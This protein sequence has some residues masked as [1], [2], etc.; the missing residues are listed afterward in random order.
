MN[1][2]APIIVSKAEPATRLRAMVVIPCLNEAAHIGRLIERLD[3]AAIRQ[4]MRII[5][6]DGGSTDGTLDILA[7]IARENPRVVILRN[8]RKLQGAAINLAVRELGDAVDCVIRV[9]AHADYPDDFCDR[10]IEEAAAT[11]ADSVVVSMIT[12]G[13]SL[14]QRAAAMAQNSKLGNGGSKHREGAKGQWV[15][16]GHHA[17]M[18]IEPFRAVGGYD[19]TFGHNEDA[20]LDHRLRTA[21]YRI[22]LTGKTRMIYYPRDTVTGLFR[23]YLNYGQ[24]RARNILKHR[25]MPKLRQTLPAMILPLAAGA[26]LA[27]FR[28]WAAVPFSLW[29]V[30]CLGY[31]VVLGIGHRDPRAFLASIAI[32]VMHFAWSVGFWLQMLNPRRR[33]KRSP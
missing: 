20:E 23:Q 2:E 16:H 5:V 30:I 9:D 6:A 10:L 27:L 24:G 17:L 29:V 4:D 11:G 31:G 25:A 32:M 3:G 8:R 1:C 22:W 12:E 21:G 15:D 28:W 14:F 33:G 19:E 26:L 13:R 7:R 18:R